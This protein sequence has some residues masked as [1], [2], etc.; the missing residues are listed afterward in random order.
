MAANVCEKLIAQ[1]LASLLLLRLLL[2]AIVCSRAIYVIIYKFLV[3][4]FCCLFLFRIPLRLRTAFAI[5]SALSSAQWIIVVAS[6][7]SRFSIDVVSVWHSQRPG[8][9]YRKIGTFPQVRFLLAEIIYESKNHHKRGDTLLDHGW[10][11][12]G[13]HFGFCDDRITWQTHKS[14]HTISVGPQNAHGSV[15]KHSRRT[16]KQICF[17]SCFLRSHRSLY[18]SPQCSRVLWPTEVCEYTNFDDYVSVANMK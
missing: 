3:I 12:F 13:V 11:T 6:W 17:F 16:T 10:A 4:F 15:V 1:A 14:T 2:V 5:V 7:F 9:Q 18:A 8:M